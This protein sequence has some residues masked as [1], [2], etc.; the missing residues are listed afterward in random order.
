MWTLC[1]FSSILSNLTDIGTVHPDLIS[2]T[3]ESDTQVTSQ[4][5]KV[6][7]NTKETD[8]DTA[9]ETDNNLLYTYFM[10]IMLRCLHVAVICFDNKHCWKVRWR[11][12]AMFGVCQLISGDY[13]CQGWGADCFIE[14]CNSD[15]NWWRLSLCSP[16]CLVWSVLEGS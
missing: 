1:L 16:Y 12:I 14:V 8:K 11:C 10:Y 15:S 3:Q 6:R 7:L 4:T 5:K 9:K 2:D 13:Y